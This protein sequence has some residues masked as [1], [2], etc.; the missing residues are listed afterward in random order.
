MII[1]N[2]E[3]FKEK[4]LGSVNDNSYS[5]KQVCKM[6][7]SM[8][9]KT[10]KRQKEI[11]DYL[12]PVDNYLV[13]VTITESKDAKHGAGIRVKMYPVPKVIGFSD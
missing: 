12:I 6:I 2:E 13:A 7:S 11:M 1:A 10:I 5:K 8:T 4:V 9:A 3:E